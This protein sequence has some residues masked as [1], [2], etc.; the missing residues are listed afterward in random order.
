MPG[1]RPIFLLAALALAAPALLAQP[2]QARGKARHASAPTLDAAAINAAEPGDQTAS[3][4]GSAKTPTPLLIRA[5]I[6]L[7]RAHFSPGSIDGRTG[8]N[9]KGALA[10]FATANGVA[11]G[12]RLTPDLWAKLAAG[13]DPAV[14]EYTV[15]EE[16]A[17]T[18]FVGRVPAKMEEQA[19]LERLGYADAAE[20]FAE[21][22]H[23][24][25]AL[26]KALN[27]GRDFGKAGTVLLVAN[28]PA[29]TLD[30][31]RAKEKDGPRVT[32][33]EVDKAARRL[34]AYDKEGG[35]VGVFPASIGSTD[36]PAPSGTLTVKGVALDP[37]YTYDPKY[38][39]KGVKAKRKFSIEPG[40][41]NPVGVAWIDLS[42][43]SYGIHGTAEPDRVGKSASHGCVRLTNWDVRRLAGL[44][45]RGA[46]VE[47]KD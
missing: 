26:L 37:V 2:A 13:P 23:M 27:P 9:F 16:D 1:P 22:F 43:D 17:K 39:F 35:V 20:M 7:D 21:R 29:M 40:P 32:R 38:A 41:N 8:D 30:K 28:V 31:A 45:E 44:V 4:P 36:K 24:D 25:E 47:F 46:K 14:V 42:E 12:A 11:D 3:L 34:T 10:A 6:L 33:I 15:T 5:Q 19:D 18:R